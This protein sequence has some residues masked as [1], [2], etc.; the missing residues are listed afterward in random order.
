MM[1]GSRH[2]LLPVCATAALAVGLSQGAQAARPLA[3]TSFELGRAASGE[4]CRAE[5]AWDDPVTKAH[6]FDRGFEV[7]CRG[8]T[9]TQSAGHIY[10]ITKTPA[11]QE[12][13]A[14]TRAARLNCGRPRPSGALLRP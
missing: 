4:S 1:S 3:S 6:H 14:K 7:Q 11:A 13:L 2:F 10:V 5:S 12:I 8:W 9:D